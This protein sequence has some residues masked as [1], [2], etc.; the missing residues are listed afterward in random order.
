MTLTTTANRRAIPALIGGALGLALS[1]ATLYLRLSGQLGAP[2]NVT[3]LAN[4]IAYPLLGASMSAVGAYLSLRK[5][6][7]LVCW[8]TLA[9]G[10]AVALDSF[11]QL[12]PDHWANGWAWLLPYGVL[13][14]LLLYYPT[15]RLLSPR[16]RWVSWSIVIF[17]LGFIGWLAYRSVAGATDY[18]FLEM[19]GPFG[20][21]HIW[22]Y[23]MSG[24]AVMLAVS[25]LALGLRFF[26]ARGEVRQQIKWLLLVAALLVVTFLVDQ[27][28][29]SQLSLLL[30]NLAAL[31]IPIVLAIAIL[32]YRLFDIDVIIRRTTSYAV[33][34]SL[35]ALIYFSSVFLI[36]QLLAPITGQ[37][38]A[39]VVL[40]TLLI[41]V[42]FLPVRRL[43][44][45]AVDRRFNRRRYDAERTLEAFAATVRNETDLDA[46]TTE[47]LGVIQQTMEPE[48]MSIWLRE[49]DS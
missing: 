25:L 4:N 28:F 17:L 39:A 44:Q 49:R 22:V 15:G 27:L 16:W 1:A 7:N 2:Q 14:L 29:H 30:D 42:V 31:C 48:T 5:P 32:R 23:L 6:D 11:V 24:V 47:L 26:R 43:V 38:D 21:Q 41:A 18:R 8:L 20:M 34:T 13:A 40:S 19:P 9:G 3:D 35:L 45:S 46:L 10:A 33:I 12:F 37:S 36:Q